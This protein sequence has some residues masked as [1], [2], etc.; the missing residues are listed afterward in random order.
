MSRIK[1]GR[2]RLVGRAAREKPETHLPSYITRSTP[3]RGPVSFPATALRPVATSSSAPLR[4]FP[5][6]RLAPA[7]FARLEGL[8]PLVPGPRDGRSNPVRNGYVA[9]SQPAVGLTRR[10]A[11]SSATSSPSMYNGN[12]R[13]VHKP[14]PDETVGPSADAPIVQVLR[15]AREQLNVA[16]RR[17]AGNT[18][19]SRME[20]VLA[21]QTAVEITV[22]L[23]LRCG[24]GGGQGRALTR[25]CGEGGV[26]MDVSARLQKAVGHDRAAPVAEPRC[27]LWNGAHIN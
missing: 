5:V 23:C 13:G 6:Q 4:A 26:R 17:A 24:G 21:A 16:A 22:R 8:S 18:D 15:L 27:A 3:A 2:K 11:S 19:L 9:D 1:S 7:K 10:A 20:A 12:M 14:A 25:A